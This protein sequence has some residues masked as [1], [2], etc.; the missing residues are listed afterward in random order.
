LQKYDPEYDQTSTGS[1][2]YT[3]L[4]PN[5][6]RVSIS[7]PANYYTANINLFFRSPTEV[8][9]YGNTTDYYGSYTDWG[10]L[11][12]TYPSSYSPP[13][14]FPAPSALPQDQILQITG[15]NSDLSLDLAGGTWTD[16]NGGSGSFTHTYTVQSGGV[17]GLTLN[18]SGQ[19]APASPEHFALRFTDD[20]VGE[21][22][23]SSLD[24]SQSFNLV[25][26]PTWEPYDNFSG[27]TIDTQKW[28]FAY[29]DGGNLPTPSNGR[30][31]LSGNTV[32][33]WNATE[34][35]EAMLQANGDAVN[36]V[37]GGAGAQY[38]RV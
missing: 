24:G 15:T 6:G 16:A 38:L 20:G 7:D 2:T 25:D 37:S 9:F 29:W 35:T 11:A 34:V 12:A 27:S 26:A 8:Y 19:N 33:N 28:D 5:L 23:Y 18:R 21:V 22:A 1:Y 14:I 13:A 17:A 4:G 30:T 3:K 31:L 36:S 10:A 32:S